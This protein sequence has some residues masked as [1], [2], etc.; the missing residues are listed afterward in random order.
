MVDS[1]SV[2]VMAGCE[3]NADGCRL[4]A[5]IPTQ[6]VGFEITAIS[7]QPTAISRNEDHALATCRRRSTTP[8]RRSRM[9]PI[10]PMVTMQ[11]MMCS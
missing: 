11:R 3:L 6:A 9:K 4:S 1:L 10:T 8:I 2:M 5:V 7:F